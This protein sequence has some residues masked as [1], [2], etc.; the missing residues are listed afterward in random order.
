MSDLGD[1]VAECER[2]IDLL[3]RRV[4]KLEARLEAT[5][6]IATREATAE[7]LDRLREAVGDE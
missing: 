3:E 2:K 6:K 7:V 1:Y 5:I 4:V